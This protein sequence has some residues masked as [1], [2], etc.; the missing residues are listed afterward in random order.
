MRLFATVAGIALTFALSACGDSDMPAHEAGALEAAVAHEI[1]ADPA[2]AAASAPRLEQLWV[3]TGFDAPE[4]AALGPDGS[5]F[6]SNVAG[7]GSAKAGNGFV[8]KVGTDGTVLMLRWADGLNAPKGMTVL[9]D[10]LYVADIDQIVTFDAHSGTKQDTIPIDGAKMLNDMTVWKDEVLVSDSGT[11]SIHRLTADGPQLLGYSTD[12]AGV[13]GVLGDGDR[14]LIT[15]M[16]EGYLIDFRGADAEDILARGMKNA[17]GV[18]LVPG[19]GYLVSSWP[20]Q[21]HYVSEDGQVT[22]LQDTQEA[23]ILQN[24]LSVFG[25]VVIVPNWMPGTVTA[26]RVVRD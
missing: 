10:T 23:G 3:T 26:W 20:G 9:G 7:D 18:G 5:Y 6:I 4:G 21:I 11:A 17:D 2:M 19:G 13:N 24:D 15:T 8:S 22:T 16:A 14:L 1:G 12:W 25:D